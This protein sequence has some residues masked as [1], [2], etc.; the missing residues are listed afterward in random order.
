MIV[1]KKS[2]LAAENEAV[3][4]PNA[5]YFKETAFHL[6][7]LSSP[8]QCRRFRGRGKTE[9]FFLGKDAPRLNYPLFE[10]TYIEE[11][12]EMLNHF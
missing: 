10:M 9:R 3:G 4:L 12:K 6:R 8:P 7:C 1:Q 2:L 11:V 5:D